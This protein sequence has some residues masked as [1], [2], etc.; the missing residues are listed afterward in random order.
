MRRQIRRCRLS[1]QGAISSCL[2]VLHQLATVT[3]LREM[4]AHFQRRLESDPLQG[5]MPGERIVRMHP[6]GNTLEMS[7]ISEKHHLTWKAVSPGE[8]REKLRR[9]DAENVD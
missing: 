5:I 2:R 7:I 3:I 8:S 1:R 6:V 4:P 9:K